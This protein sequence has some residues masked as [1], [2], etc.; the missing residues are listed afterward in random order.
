MTQTC[1]HC[2]FTHNCYCEAIPTIASDLYLTLLTHPNELGRATNTGKLIAKMLAQAEITEWQRKQPCPRCT[3][4]SNLH[5]PVLLFPSENSVSIADWQA[6]HPGKSHFIV[7]DAT[8]QEAKKM[9]NRSTWLQS[10]P[11]VHIESAQASQYQLRRNQ[12]SGNLCTFE[13]C[14]QLV[15]ELGDEDRANVMLTFFNDYLQRF[16]AERSGHALHR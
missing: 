9:L 2:G 15:R 1:T 13:V 3:G 4:D 5:P 8:W 10:L 6:Q 14:A 16:Q 11:Q 12:Q 7:L